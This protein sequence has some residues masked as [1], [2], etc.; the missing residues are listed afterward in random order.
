[1]KQPQ[2]YG[3]VGFRSYKEYIGSEYW[4]DKRDSIIISL[5]GKCKYCNKKAEFKWLYKEIITSDGELMYRIPLKA[6]IVNRN[7]LTVHHRNYNSL[8]NERLD[9]FEIVCLKC[10]RRIHKK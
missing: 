3:F 5:G 2:N 10:H 4:K 1:M 8:G 6:I 9:D 7:T